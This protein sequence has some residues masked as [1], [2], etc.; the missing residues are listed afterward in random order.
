[1]QKKSAASRTLSLFDPFRET[2]GATPIELPKFAGMPLFSKAASKETLGQLPPDDKQE[3]PKRRKKAIRSKSR[4]NAEERSKRSVKEAK[5]VPSLEKRVQACEAKL[6]TVTAKHS[7][8]CQKKAQSSRFARRDISGMNN[9]PHDALG[10]EELV[11]LAQSHNDRFIVTAILA[12]AAGKPTIEALVMLDRDNRTADGYPAQI[13]VAEDLE[14][15]MDKPVKIWT[16]IARTA[17]VGSAKG[18]LRRELAQL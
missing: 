8:Q 1:M 12:F 7:C 15:A 17:G 2:A 11:K 6:A 16:G 3:Q 18:L 5:R 13:H 10:N 9:I 14:D 4:R